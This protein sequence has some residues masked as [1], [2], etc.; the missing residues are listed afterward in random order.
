M[1]P[2]MTSKVQFNEKTIR[3]FLGLNK[4][5][6]MSVGEITE[7][8]NMTSLYFPSLGTRKERI[9]LSE[10]EGIING[11]S[12][13]E[14]YIFTSYL[15]E[16]SRMFLNYDGTNYEFTE[17]TDSQPELTRRFASLSDSILIIPDNIIFYTNSRSFSKICVSSESNAKKT[18][19]KFAEETN[20]SDIMDNAQIRYIA[21]YTHN[22]ITYRLAN[23]SINGSK[24]FY[25]SNFDTSLKS[26]DVINLKMTVFSDSEEEDDDYKKYVKKMKI[27]IS[28]KIKDITSVT[29]STINGDI[30]ETVGLIFED[31]TIDC[32]GY[33]NLRISKITVERGMPV[34]ENICSHNNRIWAT[35]GNEIYTSKLGD[36][37]EWNDFSVDSYGLLPYACFNTKAETGGVF[38]G[39]IPYGNFIFAFKENAIHKVHGNSPDEYSLYSKI[40]TGLTS[41]SNLCLCTGADCI[42]YPSSDGIYTY[43]DDFPKCISEKLN[44]DFTPIDACSNNRYYYLLASYENK[45][46]LFV[47]DLKRKIWH[48][49]DAPED[50]AFLASHGKDIYLATKSKVLQIDSVAPGEDKKEIVFWNFKMDFD[51]RHFEKRGYGTISLRYSLEKNASF[52]VRT[53][54][55]DNTKGAI[56]GAIYD[57]NQTD[58]CTIIIPVKRCRRFILEF[59]GRGFFLLKGLKLKFY[60]GSEI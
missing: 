40:C 32:G 36:A 51:D 47:Y 12:T 24:V 25:Y 42:I 2:F 30:T 33:K 46:I 23:Y 43:S 38:T 5:E 45:C 56:C 3:T 37:S 55:D 19:E 26:G 44:F 10:T 27:G 4:S 29:H 22:S 28:V 18:R 16:S 6:D 14:G 49:Q 13:F 7:S 48:S 17:F 8:K 34:L 41:G 1:L 39:I 58:G 11:L 54:Y 52:T 35:A 20:N 31:N 21:S 9:T 50:S 60:Q 57:E 15:P 59:S 53:I